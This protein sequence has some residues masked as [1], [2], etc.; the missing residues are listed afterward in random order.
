[1]ESTSAPF[2]R[3]AGAEATSADK[4]RTRTEG[5]A[6]LR[7]RFVYYL[8]VGS[9]V[10]DRFDNVRRAIRL[11]E[12]TSAPLVDADSDKR[13]DDGV[14]SASNSS[15]LSSSAA[16]MR[17]KVTRTS[18]LYETP[19]M[20]L[21]EQPHF[22]NAAVRVEGEAPVKVDEKM[23]SGAAA[24]TDWSAAHLLRHI[25]H[26]E[27]KL[28]RELQ[29]SPFYVRNGPRPID[30][31][32]LMGHYAQDD[33]DDSD[34][35]NRQ[36]QLNHHPI[37]FDTDNL[38]VPHPRISERRFV[39]VPLEDVAGREY[40][41]PTLNATVGELLRNQLLT[42]GAAATP[43]EETRVLPLPRQRFL[44][45]NRTLLMGILNVT[46]DSF[47]DGNKYNASVDKAARQALAMARDG[48]DIVDVGGESTRPG[49]APVDVEEELSRVI[50]VIRRIRSL[51][52]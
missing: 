20:Y 38:T 19:P 51:G 21:S 4:T 32:I 46:P 15:L 40:R 5:N 50:P 23:G 43:N 45:L 3:G 27:R 6:L 31:D 44:H 47:S 14:A 28:G 26:V 33:D 7:R 41:H 35:S 30:L 25:K 22:L 1:V 34:P 24:A 13:D 2:R 18:F 42:N 8:G 17:L 29:N 48:A 37:A 9:N 52:R 16:L 49:A 11:L 39:L 36:Q 12:E 10:G